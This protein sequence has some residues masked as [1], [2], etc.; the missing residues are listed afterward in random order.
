MVS[1]SAC[2]CDVNMGDVCLFVCL[3]VYLFIL[4]RKLNRKTVY[5]KRS[6]AK[7]KKRRERKEEK[8]L[9]GS[10]SITNL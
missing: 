10:A 6:Y 9:D 7:G 8:Q 3:F 5:L 4:G 1:C 2:E